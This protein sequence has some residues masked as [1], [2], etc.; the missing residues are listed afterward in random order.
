MK[1][2]I[3]HIAERVTAAASTKQPLSLRCGGSKD[4]Y[5]NPAM[6]ETLDI[7]S[8][9]GVSSYE[10][11]ELYITA[12]AATPLAEIETLLAENQQ[13][14]AFEPP[15]FGETATIGGT[16]ACGFSGP[17]RPAAGALRDHVLGVGMINGAGEVLRFGGT[18][19]KNVAGFD[20]SR[21]MAGS[22][23]TL[24]IIT[25]VTFRVTPKPEAELT[26]VMECDE[27]IAIDSTNRLLA[28]GSPITASVWHDNLLWRRFAGGTEAVQ[29]AVSEVGGD[30]EDKA[31]AFW[32]SV[33]EQTHPFFVGNNNL[34]RT[35]VPAT[36]PVA[37]G[38][39]LIEWHGAV[40]W[41]RGSA[42]SAQE[43]AAK[44]GGSATLFRTTQSETTERFPPLAPPIAKIHRN[45]KKAFDP[46]DILNRGRMYDFSS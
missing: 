4:F 35:M 14:L 37:A 19:L 34:W 2:T 24:G 3:S 18:V 28:Q 46:H 36:M 7:S 11:S 26:T 31:T 6:G 15:H 8:L 45:L 29:R 40:R 13:M 16:L 21:L 9:S 42:K 27:M 41:Q 22:L 1:E 20:V 10:A 32:Q 33:R 44:A 23:G 17:R 25:D 39:E 43:A 12:G 5:G 30:I 38:D